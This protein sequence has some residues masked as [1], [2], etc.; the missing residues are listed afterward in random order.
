MD[1]RCRVLLRIATIITGMLML[2]STQTLKLY[3][4]Q[5]EFPILFN[6]DIIQL[7][8]LLKLTRV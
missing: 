8:C 2:H 6:L 1:L 5:L 4:V 7:T 3:H